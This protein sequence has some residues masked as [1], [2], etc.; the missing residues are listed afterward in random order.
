MR[1]TSVLRW[2][3][4]AVAFTS[5]GGCTGAPLTRVYPQAAPPAVE[6]P[7]S[8]FLLSR[9]S[10][11]ATKESLST[12]KGAKGA[13]ADSASS[14]VAA[15]SVSN[16]APESSSAENEGKIETKALNKR[17]AASEERLGS[18]RFRR[19]EQGVLSSD[20]LDA[21]AQEAALK[22]TESLELQ[23]E[24]KDPSLASES[25][26]ASHLQVGVKQIFDQLLTGMLGTGVNLIQGGAMGA[27]PMTMA[28]AVGFGPAPA[29]YQAP[30][31]GLSTVE[32]ILIISGGI[33]VIGL[34]GLL[35]WLAT[36]KKSRRR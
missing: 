10:Q 1:G 15:S 13:L 28:P 7:K 30:D 11:K 6:G 12:A 33:L 18:G 4:V 2:L 31:T 29:Y 23:A 17:L 32:I 9:S 14:A 22:A 34:V 3:L 25:P 26:A 20:A 35:V 5:L 21:E 24:S 8:S 27:Q 16:E 36:R 19:G